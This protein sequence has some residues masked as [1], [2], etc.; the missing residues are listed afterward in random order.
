MI[1]ITVNGQAREVAEGSTLAD[2][3]AQLAASPQALATAVNGDFVA[4]DLRAAHL[5]KP[6]DQVF[7]F[8]PITGG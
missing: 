8:Q 3:V 7:T 5:L 1:A 2:L 6:G 4:R